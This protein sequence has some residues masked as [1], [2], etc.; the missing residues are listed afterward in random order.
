[1]DNYSFDRLVALLIEKNYRV[2]AAES[3]TGGLF[4]AGVVSVADA[5]KVFDRGFVTYS[6]AA[7]TALVGVPPEMIAGYGVVSEQT[8]AA[9]AKGACIKAGADVGVGITGFAGPSGGDQFAPLGTVCFGFCVG[10]SVSTARMD[11]GA[12]GRNSVREAAV[13]FACEKLCALLET[14]TGA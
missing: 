3:C 6:E 5:S 7:K 10:G 12:I 2:T 8:A 9:M 11:W 4:C 14:E 1:M 13:R